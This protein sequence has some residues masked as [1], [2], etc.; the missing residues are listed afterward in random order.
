[1]EKLNLNNAVFNKMTHE[2]IEK[3]FIGKNLDDIKNIIKNND[4]YKLDNYYNYDFNNKTIASDIKN[5]FSVSLYEYNF[6]DKIIRKY[7][8]IFNAEC[9]CYNIIEVVY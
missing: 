5:Y 4:S 7:E 2:Y 8:L 1:M 3:N 6:Y 9:I